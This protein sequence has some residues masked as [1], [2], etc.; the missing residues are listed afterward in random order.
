[1]KTAIKIDVW[2]YMQ[3]DHIINTE[4]YIELYLLYL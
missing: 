1:M 4:E 3:Y 2:S